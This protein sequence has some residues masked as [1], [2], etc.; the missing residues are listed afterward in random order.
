[1][2]VVV[3]TVT[4]VMAVLVLVLV[5]VVLMLMRRRPRA[6]HP[7]AHDRRPHPEHQQPRDEVQPRIELLGQHIGRQR[8]RHRPEREDADRV[9]DRHRGP[10]GHGM[11][12]G[13]ARADEI[14]GHHRLAVPGRERVHGAPSEGGQQEQQQDALPGGRALEDRAE[15]VARPAVG[16]RR[17]AAVAAR[18]GDGPAAGAHPQMGDGAIGGAREQRGRVHAQAAGGIGARHVAAHGGAATGLDEDGAPA[19]APG[20]RGVAHHDR[21]PG[22]HLRMQ[23]H[24]HAGGVQPPGAPGE[25]RCARPGAASGPRAGPPTVRVTPRAHVGALA[26][27]HRAPASSPRSWKV[28]ISAWSST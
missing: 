15:A 14:G 3:M 5:V 13:A 20:E 2:V 24:L 23:Q 9:G 26:R 21:S 25:A 18:R 19:D 1:M 22:R 12:R 4:V 17:P 7:A 10:E 28:G 11:A 27:E 16:R 8:E 6:T